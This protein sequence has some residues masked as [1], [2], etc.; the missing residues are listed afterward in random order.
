MAAIIEQICQ[1]VQS[2]LEQVTTA[3]GYSCNF[4][5]KRPTRLGIQSPKDG[6]CAIVWSGRFE[7]DERINGGHRAVGWQTEIH[8]VLYVIPSDKSTEAIDA[9]VSER[10]DDCIAALTDATAWGTWG[11]LAV[12][13][14]ITGAEGFPEEAGDYD[15]A[16]VNMQVQFITPENNFSAVE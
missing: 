10:I 8:L 9:I 15:G 12:E 14:D 6:T 1:A 4:I 3:N 16:V 5:V 13:S 11:G 2:R 7:R